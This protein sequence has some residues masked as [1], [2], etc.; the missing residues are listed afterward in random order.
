MISWSTWVMTS[1]TTSASL[2]GPHGH[3]AATEQPPVGP[4]RERLGRVPSAPRSQEPGASAPGAR[5]GGSHCHFSRQ[6]GAFHMLLGLFVAREWRRSHHPLTHN[7]PLPLLLPLLLQLLLL[8]RARGLALRRG[9]RRATAAAAAAAGRC[10]RGQRHRL[11]SLSLRGEPLLE[12]ALQ[13]RS[14]VRVRVGVG[15]GV[16]VRV[17]GW[18]QG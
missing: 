1:A 3:R 17:G 15:V 11:L 8:L 2:P 6:D 5:V 13:V 14:R 16:R 12:V 10:V 18:G 4:S 9:Q 7:V